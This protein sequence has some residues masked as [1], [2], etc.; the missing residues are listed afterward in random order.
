MW[1]KWLVITLAFGGMLLFDGLALRGKLTKRDKLLYGAIVVLSLFEG[2]D[3][4]MSLEWPDY[5]DLAQIPF[6]KAAKAI[7]QALQTDWES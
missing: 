4:A 2:I 5:L 3:F 1:E 6:G 7:E